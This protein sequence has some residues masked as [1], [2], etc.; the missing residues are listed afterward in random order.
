MP[1]YVYKV[2]TND[3]QTQKGK[4][5]AVNQ[6]KAA[7]TLQERGLLVI[8]LT[9]VAEK[10][11]ALVEKSSSMT[12]NDTVLF[13]RQLAS[14]VEAGLT[15][16]NAIS[17]L[18]QQAKP[19]VAAVLSQLVS[20]LE[21]GLSFTKALEKHPKVFSKTYIFL[22]QAG[23]SSGSLDKVLGR[24][25]NTM[26]EQREFNGK[27]RNALIYPIVVMIVMVA[28][29]VVMMVA[30]V[31]KL[32]SVFEEFNAQLPA[33]TL[34]LIAISNFLI[35]YWWLLLIILAIAVVSFWVWYRDE[36]AKK[37][38]DRL[39]FRIP[40]VGDLR[41]K[42]ILANFTQTLA[43]LIR[44]GVP[45]VDSLNLATET[46]NSIVYREYFTTAKDKVEKGV[47]LGD[48]LE[49]YD[50][51][52]PILVQMI[53][54]GEETGKLDD[55]MERLSGYFKAESQ[56]AITGLMAAFEPVLMIV[57]GLAVAFLVI[58]IILPIYNLTSQ[59]V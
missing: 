13:T 19:T 12:F 43:M 59:V 55:I 3:G 46:M 28:V 38:V 42:T 23:E 34:I 11:N 35:N 36:H 51:L 54:V 16:T 32:L 47:N 50:D 26:E 5:E 1:F 44:S 48:A 31:P 41:K 30:V 8:S 57:L 58:A 27:I 24:L 37:V 56:Q 45:L 17:L 10:K 14:M 9:P 40:L 2:R 7:Q 33:P 49:I 29:V 15:L 22:V 6:E 18:T 39:Y 4:V 52:P 25:A 21:N 53:K 20:D